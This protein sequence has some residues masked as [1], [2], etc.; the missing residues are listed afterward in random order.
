MDLKEFLLAFTSDWV[1]L[2]SGIASVAITI[3]G[4]AKKW[5]QVPRWTFWAA[6]VLCFFF[7]SCRIWTAEHRKYLTETEKNNPQL[8]I[9]LG[10]LYGMPSADGKNTIV[11][12]NTV[13]V[14][15]GAQS[16]VIGWKATFSSATKTEN[17][18]VTHFANPMRFHVGN[19]LPDLVVDPKDDLVEKTMSVIPHNG[20]VSGRVTLQFDGDVRDALGDSRYLLTVS[21]LDALGKASIGEYRG[22]PS[23]D[24]EWLPVSPK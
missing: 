21:I 18:P 1:S 10:Q 24:F 6:A 3:I 8:V 4:L 7:G 9:K 2:M 23:K 15:R 12:V 17:I 11:A 22:G 14:N 5:D 20:E 13:I 16:A 19:N